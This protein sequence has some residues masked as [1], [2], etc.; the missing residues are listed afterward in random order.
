[1]VL[2]IICTITVINSLWFVEGGHVYNLDLYL[3]YENQRENL[4][5]QS[6]NIGQQDFAIQQLKDT[7]S[8]VNMDS[9]SSTFKA[10]RKQPV[11]ACHIFYESNL[12]LR[13]KLG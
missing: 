1:M 2:L 11:H 5:N 6:F 9:V 10:S 4:S 7:K 13:T 8:T 3:R 12:L